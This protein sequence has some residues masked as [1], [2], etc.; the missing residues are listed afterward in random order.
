MRIVEKWLKVVMPII[1]LIL[2]IILC[3][4]I[5]EKEVVGTIFRT[6]LPFIFSFLIAWILNPAVEKIS[7]RFKLPRWLSALIVIVVII[8]V[9]AGMIIVI[10]PEMVDQVT[11]LVKYVPNIEPAITESF[12]TIEDFIGSDFNF[13]IFDR[14]G[15]DIS[16]FIK[17][18]FSGSLEVISTSFTIVGGVISSVFIAFMVAMASVYILIDFNKLTAKVNRV[19]PSRMKKDFKFLSKEVNRVIVGYLRGLIIETFIVGFLAYIAFLIFGVNGALVFG[20]IIGITN[21]IPYIG[22]YV[23]AVPVSIFALTESFQLFII[24]IILVIV[25]QQIDGIIIKPKVFGK[26]TDVHPALSIIAIILF[27]NI[28]GIIGVIFAIPITGLIII[29]A[30]FIYSKLLIKYPDVLR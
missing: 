2:I 26:T 23:G 20:A 16:E 27:G 19:I 30:K 8:C 13:D 17:N 28:Y 11:Y 9:V 25:I 7:E 24:V 15:D 5:S 6:L 3:N 29:A 1:T 10:I 12:E 22:P 4:L 14:F 18:I 21:I